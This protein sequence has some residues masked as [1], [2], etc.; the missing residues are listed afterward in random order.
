MPQGLH[1]PI[2]EGPLIGSF[3][4]YTGAKGAA[5]GSG[6]GGGGSSVGNINLVQVLELENENLKYHQPFEDIGFGTFV[7]PKGKY[8]MPI[9]NYVIASVDKTSALAMGY[10]TVKIRGP[11]YDLVFQFIASVVNGRNP[12]IKVLNSNLE[13]QI[14]GWGNVIMYDDDANDKWRICLG[15]DETEK[16]PVGTP[17]A[18][19]TNV[20][21][22]GAPAPSWWINGGQSQQ[23]IEYIR[24]TLVNNNANQNNLTI[25][26]IADGNWE[27]SSKND[28]RDITLAPIHSITGLWGGQPIDIPFPPS[29]NYTYRYKVISKL[30]LS[31]IDPSGNISS[32]TAVNVFYKDIAL[33]HNTKIGSWKF[34]SNATNE[35]QLA[36]GSGPGSGFWENVRTFEPK[37][38]KGDL[39][40]QGEKINMDSK[41]LQI[42]GDTNL[43][44]KITIDG[45][46]DHTTST[47]IKE[48]NY[49]NNNFF[50]RTTTAGTAGKWQ[51]IAR[52]ETFLEDVHL[53]RATAIFEVF[54]KSN[55]INNTAGVPQ[56]GV[57]GEYDPASVDD[58]ILFSVSWQYD[59]YVGQTGFHD[60]DPNTGMIAPPRCTINVINSR[61]GGN[62]ILYWK[63]GL[64]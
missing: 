39:T 48:V 41:L 36:N 18:P 64:Y 54:D 4:R 14:D 17:N 30:A 55:T 44:G 20:N 13:S 45:D 16:I 1:Y 15:F 12:T 51:T 25:N 60:I 23:T 62:S 32:D 58:Y 11:N 24:I 10:F 52:T 3:I 53:R 50:T 33:A 34:D 9:A 31:N 28:F 29:I 2:T 42:V 35:N 26:P 59:T 5:G 46:I 61:C 43:V 56:G 22:A 37:Y 8:Y 63:H 27:L 40:I 21:P 6:G 7:P 19:W 38:N 49:D 47:V 57:S